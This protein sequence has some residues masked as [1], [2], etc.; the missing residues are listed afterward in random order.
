MTTTERNYSTYSER[1]LKKMLDTTESKEAKLKAEF[2][3]L[4]AKIKAIV[5][6]RHLIQDA[7]MQK[8]REPSDELLEAIA[9]IERGEFIHCENFDEYLKAVNEKD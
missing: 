7:I 6:K 1:Q 4:K 5:E 9:E 3:A 8:W 2:F